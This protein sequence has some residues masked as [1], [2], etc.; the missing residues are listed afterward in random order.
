MV[1]PNHAVLAKNPAFRAAC[2]LVVSCLGT[3]VSAAEP[4]VER[5]RDATR[6]SSAGAE[7]LGT[8]T[9]SSRTHRLRLV[10]LE[11]RGDKRCA[12]DAP[13]MHGFRCRCQQ[14]QRTGRGVLL[15]SRSPPTLSTPDGSPS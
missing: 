11:Q 8:T 12:R 10:R 6:R 9:S 15:T 2:E 7:S 1:E 5:M 3:I 14:R 13:V 4:S